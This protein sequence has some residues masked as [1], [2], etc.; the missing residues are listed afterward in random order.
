MK[1]ETRVKIGKILFVFFIMLIIGFTITA[2]YL[3]QFITHT[4][5]TYTVTTYLPEAP[6]S[7]SLLMDYID[8]LNPTF[9]EY[10]YAQAR[11]ESG[12][13]TSNVFIENNN[14]FG[15]TTVGNRTTTAIGSNHGFAVYYNWRESVLDYLIYQFLYMG[16]KTEDEY[17]QHLTKYYA[18]DSLYIFK[19]KNIAEDY[20][21]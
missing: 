16:D 20:K 1:N 14:L 6:F 3:K 17:L 19:I 12:N 5:E 11:L 18:T 21:P 10:V 13:Y 4:T 15:M 2:I 7:D 9:P 8:N